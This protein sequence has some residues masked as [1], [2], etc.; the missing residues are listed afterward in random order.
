MDIHTHKHTQDKAEN[1]QA[2]TDKNSTLRHKRRNREGGLLGGL[3][4][5]GMVSRKKR[6]GKLLEVGPW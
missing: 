2:K 3:Q 5:D 1:M 4:G 6:K